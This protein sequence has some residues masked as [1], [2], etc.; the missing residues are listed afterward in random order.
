[1]KFLILSLS[2]LFVSHVNSLDIF[3]RKTKAEIA[4]EQRRAATAAL[5]V[6]NK[7]IQ[8][9]KNYA[10][11]NIKKSYTQLTSEINSLTEDV[12]EAVY[13]KLQTDQEFINAVASSREQ[14]NP[15]V[16]K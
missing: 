8:S 7:I 16:N 9:N 11:Q 2:T 15:G 13:L 4:A 6:K 14:L 5:A 10:D 3:G 12:S 1:M